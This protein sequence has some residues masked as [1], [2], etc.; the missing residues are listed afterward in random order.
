MNG[1][2]PSMLARL[3]RLALLGTMGAMIV[4]ATGCATQ[5]VGYDYTAFK[6]ARP[7]SILV[8]PPLNK[9]TDVTASN[10]ILAQVTLPLGEAG[11]YVMPVTLVA[12]TFK[13]NGMAL[14]AEMHQAPADK[15][16]QIFG[17]DAAL[18]ITV[19]QFGAVYNVINSATVAT[20]DA[21]LVD[22]RT[23]T[24]LWVGKASASSEEGSNSSGGGLVGLLVTAIVKQ[25]IANV[26]DQSHRIGG[27][28]T[29]RLLTGGLPNGILYGPRS[30]NAGKEVSQ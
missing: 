30:P 22:L 12:E 7:A 23:G 2:S 8:L 9:T 25:V 6:Q 11:Y 20:A 28:A 3:T 19:S 4:L 15:L 24:L 14:P 26:S 17:A 16:R 1:T 29:A 10:S 5:R 27:L 13:E 18:Y 21:K